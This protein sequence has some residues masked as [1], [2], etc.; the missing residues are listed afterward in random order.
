MGENFTK[1]YD[2]IV[3]GARFAGLSAAR[4]LEMLGHRVLIPKGTETFRRQDLDG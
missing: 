3:I 1:A 4:E 2:T